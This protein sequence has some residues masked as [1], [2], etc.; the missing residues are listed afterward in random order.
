M[1]TP[2]LATFVWQLS[3]RCNIFTSLVLF[4]PV[5]L[6]VP[7]SIVLLFNAE[8]TVFAEDTIPT[9]LK[10]PSVLVNIGK[11]KYIGLSALLNVNVLLLVLSVLPSFNVLLTTTSALLVV[12]APLSK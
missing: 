9:T 6:I 1:T 8:N 2:W 3:E 12:A 11:S 4:K 10:V 5:K 7:K